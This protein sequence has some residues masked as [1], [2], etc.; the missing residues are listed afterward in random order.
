MNVYIF[1]SLNG[2]EFLNVYEV[3]LYDGHEGL[4]PFRAD[5][6]NK[7]IITIIDKK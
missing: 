4:L 6:I 1:F 3:T 5:K 2:H 7:L